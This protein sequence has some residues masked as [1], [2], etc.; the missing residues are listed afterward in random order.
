MRVVT[1]FPAATEIVCALGVDPVG[2]SH[3]CDY[4]SRVES[5]PSVTSTT[6]DLGHSSEAIDETVSDL[7]ATAAISIDGEQ[8]ARLDPDVVVTQGMCE[9]CAVDGDRVRGAVSAADSPADPHYCSLTP[10]SM[11]DLFAGIEQVA[12]A[13][14]RPSAGEQLVSSL[15]GRIDQVRGRTASA[16]PRV[17]ILDWLDPVMV[18]GHWTAELVTWAGGRYGLAGTGDHSR[19][20]EWAEIR[21]YDPDVLVLAP[22]G[23]DI[24]R[25]LEELAVVRE[26]PGFEGLTA[27]DAGRVWV[28][29][30][31]QY[32][33]RPGPRLVDTL[34]V[35]AAIF[36]SADS[37]P[38][39]AAVRVGQ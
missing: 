13:L 20:R 25:T 19:P 4:P 3:A 9:V 38:D 36:D 28:M 12:T 1:T 31:S 23:F 21:T 24:D 5:I 11:A 29:D 6:I 30:G 2:V 32:L 10:H 37:P 33:N 26:R 15:Q 34:E 7:G 8:I 22:C 35:L 14:D 39:E 18:A 17:A 27:A 16:G